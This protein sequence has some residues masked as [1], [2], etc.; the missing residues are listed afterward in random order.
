MTGL[1]IPLIELF[2]ASIAGVVFKTCWDEGKSVIPWVGRGLNKN[3]KEVTSP[4]VNSSSITLASPN[5]ETE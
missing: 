2:K 1:E 5:P 3:T 4:D